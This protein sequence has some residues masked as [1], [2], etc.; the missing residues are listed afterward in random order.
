MHK[1]QPRQS[2]P[3]QVAQ[4]PTDVKKTSGYG[5]FYVCVNFLCLPKGSSRGR[6]YSKNGTFV[7][8]N[9]LKKLNFYTLITYK[10]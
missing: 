1:I 7:L 9:G 10:M 6:M 8:M 3:R 4:L 5:K 2:N